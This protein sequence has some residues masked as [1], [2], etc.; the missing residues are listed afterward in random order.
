[1]KRRMDVSSGRLFDGLIAS[2]LLNVEKFSSL[3]R[4]VRVTAWVCRAVKKRL[5]IGTKTS[6]SS[7]W[8]VR[9]LEGR[10]KE[11]LLTVSEL[12]YALE[13]LI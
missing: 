1:M 11:P 10:F 9:P 12:V 5:K 8:E 3:S 4:L 13:D 6:G 7:K 2:K